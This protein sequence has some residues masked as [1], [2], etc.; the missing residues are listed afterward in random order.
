VCVYPVSYHTKNY[1]FWTLLI[2][3]YVVFW[4]EHI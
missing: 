2:L 3:K 1:F 4:K